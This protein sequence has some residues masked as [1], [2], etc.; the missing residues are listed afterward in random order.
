MSKTIVLKNEKN[1]PIGEVRYIDNGNATGIC[2][3]SPTFA[4]SYIKSSDL[5]FDSDGRIYCHG[6]G[7]ASLIREMMRGKI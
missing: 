7:L 2:Y 4:G 1:Y 6:D 5:T 3:R